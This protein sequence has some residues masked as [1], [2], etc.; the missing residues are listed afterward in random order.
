[1]LLLVYDIAGYSPTC[2]AVNAD[3]LAEPG[4]FKWIAY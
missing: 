4:N 1:M 2:L 3:N